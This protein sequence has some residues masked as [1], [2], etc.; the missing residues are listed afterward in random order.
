MPARQATGTDSLLR[1]RSDDR[2]MTTGG[3]SE[4]RTYGPPDDAI[5]IGSGH[6]IVLKQ[7]EGETAGLDHWHE[8][9]DGT[10]CR[11]WIDFAG[12]K[13]VQGFNG[14]VTG[15]QVV[16][17]EPLTLTPSILC[18]VCGVHGFITNGRWVRV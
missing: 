3:T 5:E 15:W 16:S 13:W 11:G 9:Q 10:W 8:R 1:A 4:K 7:F 2:A 14:L 17:A 6:K 12:S 18:R